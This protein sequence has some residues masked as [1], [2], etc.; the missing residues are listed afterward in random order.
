MSL[1]AL[2]RWD[3]RVCTQRI[4][5][6]EQVLP[7]DR[8]GFSQHI[9]GPEAGNRHGGASSRRLLPG[10]SQTPVSPPAAQG[11]DDG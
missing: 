7:P 3:S 9:L 5:S 4:G 10:Q 2:P 8:G 1:T 6:S 11:D